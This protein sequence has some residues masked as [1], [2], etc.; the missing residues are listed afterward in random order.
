MDD[1]AGGALEWHDGIASTVSSTLTNPFS[2]LQMK[3]TAAVASE[4]CVQTRA[5]HR[6]AAATGRLC[7]QCRLAAVCAAAV[8]AVRYCAALGAYKQHRNS[9][10]I[11][12]ATGGSAVC[13]EWYYECRCCD[14]GREGVPG[15]SLS[16]GMAP[17]ITNAPSSRRNSR[18]PPYLI[19]PSV[20]TRT[21]PVGVA[22]RTRAK[23]RRAAA[24]S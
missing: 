24:R 13:T 17:R 10:R 23:C 11:V 19:D 12:V 18:R 7:G 20:S 21:H 3:P 8:R 2:A 22:V 14:G 4:R 9:T 1:S 5:G 6:R 15:E 16:P